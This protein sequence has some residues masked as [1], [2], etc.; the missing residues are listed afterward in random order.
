MDTKQVVS[1]LGD[2]GKPQQVQLNPDLPQSHT[3]IR[4][5]QGA[6]KSI[7]NLGVG[8][9]DIA[10]STGPSYATKRMEVVDVLQEI[11]AKNP[12]LAPLIGDIAFRAMDVPYADQ[13]ADRMHAMLPAQLQKLDGQQGPLPPQAVAQITQLT[14]QV[15]MMQQQGQ[16]LQQENQQ[17]KSGQA[18]DM[19]KVSAQHDA[20]LKGLA[21]DQQTQQGEHER[22]LAQATRDAELKRR[23]AEEDAILKRDI[24]T[25]EAQLK[26]FVAE[27][28]RKIEDQRLAIEKQRKDEETKSKIDEQNTKDSETAMP[29]FLKT[30]E[31]LIQG[32]E[33]MNEQIAKAIT[34]PRVAEVKMPDGRIIKA[35]S[36][37]H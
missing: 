37:V 5:M 3:Q 20:K 6:I 22:M 8:E 31:T 34:A 11:M 30:L 21:M 4:D 1:I 19:A 9:Y 35:T 36:S 27:E 28:E 7:Y 29:Q 18:V 25:E 2:D 13:L 24:A 14:Q 23:I 12:N 26:K 17:L 15:Q 16:K 33:K 32:Q 10:V